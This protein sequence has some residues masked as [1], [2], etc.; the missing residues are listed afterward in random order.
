MNCGVE[1]VEEDDEE[2]QEKTKTTIKMHETFYAVEMSRDP[3]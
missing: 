3:K 2:E 1:V